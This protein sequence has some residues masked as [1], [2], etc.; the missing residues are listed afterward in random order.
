MRSKGFKIFIF[1]F[2][3]N[4][5]TALSQNIIKGKIISSDKDFQNDIV[6]IYDN[7]NG[8]VKTVKMGEVFEIIIDYKSDITLAFVAENYPIIEKKIETIEE[9]LLI[10]SLPAR[11]EK[12]SEVV[13]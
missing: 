4:Y 12:L 6:E 9:K 11:L 7:K 3:L 5:I 10:I 13:I 2:F 1:F 8:F